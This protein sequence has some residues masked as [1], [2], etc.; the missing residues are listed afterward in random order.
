MLTFFTNPSHCRQL[1]VGAVYVAC[2]M[3]LLMPSLS[4]LAWSDGPPS[5]YDESF[6]NIVL[7]II[8]KALTICCCCG[9]VRISITFFMSHP[10]CHWFITVLQETVISLGGWTLLM[11]NF[12]P[13]FVLRQNSVCTP[14]ATSQKLCDS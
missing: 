11:R 14:A 1:S 5:F 6:I 3:L 10:V 13:F 4:R 8:T 12:V 2:W 7:C 9:I